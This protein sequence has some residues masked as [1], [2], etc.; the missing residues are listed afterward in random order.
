MEKTEKDERKAIGGHARALS[1]SPEDR[2]AIA[3]KAAQA[4]WD[5]EV[6]VAKYEAPINI[7]NETLWAVVLEDGRRLITQATF[8]RALGR[9]RSPKAGTGVFSTFDQ[10]PFFLQAEGLKPFI[11][12]ELLD[13]TK[14]IFYRTK[15]G[16][17]GVG[18]N[19]E[20]VPRVCTVY[21]EFKDDYLARTGKL[22]MR[23]K[24]IVLACDL[25]IR[26]LAHVGIIALIDEATGY[27]Y[28]RA[29]LALAE[30]LEQFISK[31]LIKWVKTFP[32]EFYFQIFR[33]RGWKSSKVVSQR[34]PIFGKI[35]NDLVYER[36][37]QNILKHL[38]K[39]NP[40][41]E[42]GRRK[43]KHFQRL[44]E[45]VGQRELRTLLATEITIMKGFDDGNW[46]GFYSFL[47][48]T[49]PKQTPLPLFDNLPEYDETSL[50]A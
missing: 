35:T 39:F 48:R 46:E 4:R 49:L 9:S 16:S 10:I 45:D 11:D 26:G 2:K 32:D 14:P 27:Q 18:Y 13:S 50:L 7:G 28:D 41:D 1:L 15:S 19:A 34:P 29:R 6:P 42:D 33:L 12:N 44:T 5:V 24:K 23:Y 22:P 3:R 30:I 38:E 36:M 31:E 37:P 8:L 21:L 25:L 20:L 17:K 43:R 40:K 47:C